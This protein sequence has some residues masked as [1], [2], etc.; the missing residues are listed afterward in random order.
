[1]GGNS[2]QGSSG[3]PCSAIDD[4]TG[5]IHK[6][7][8]KTG[9]AGQNNPQMIYAEGLSGIA[10]TIKFALLEELF[11]AMFPLRDGCKLLT[12]LS[13][14]KILFGKKLNSCL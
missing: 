13:D 8:R 1:M 9:L 11:T 10:E 2:S 14:D 3:H 4:L 5:K 12:T 6:Y 7:I